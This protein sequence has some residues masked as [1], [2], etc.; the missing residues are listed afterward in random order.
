[1]RSTDAPVVESPGDWGFL[2]AALALLAIVLEVLWLTREP[3]RVE[4]GRIR[5]LRPERRGAT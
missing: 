2:A 4:A 5:P 1:V 3:A